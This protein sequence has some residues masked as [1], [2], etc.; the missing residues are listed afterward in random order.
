MQICWL[1][2]FAEFKKFSPD[3]CGVSDIFE[4]IDELE[5]RLVEVIAVGEAIGHDDV[6]QDVLKCYEGFGCIVDVS[7]GW[8]V[9]IR[10]ENADDDS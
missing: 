8:A 4:V 10:A 3:V 2:T 1:I 6:A 9:F 7:P 5:R